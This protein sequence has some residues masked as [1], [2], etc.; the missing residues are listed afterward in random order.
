MRQNKRLQTTQAL[1]KKIEKYYDVACCDDRNNGCFLTAVLGFWRLKNR[2]RNLAKKWDHNRPMA[3]HF[4]KL[5]SE[6]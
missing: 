2:N 4:L 6:P 3:I 5:I 1:K